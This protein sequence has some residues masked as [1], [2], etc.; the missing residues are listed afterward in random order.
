M[1]VV[2]DPEGGQGF[3]LAGEQVCSAVASFPPYT[4]PPM[5]PARRDT[6]NMDPVP[7]P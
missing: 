7:G 5:P 4:V 1:D 3:H 2:G 6:E